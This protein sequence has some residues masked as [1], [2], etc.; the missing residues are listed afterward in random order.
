MNPA[1]SVATAATLALWPAMAEARIVMPASHGRFMMLHQ[2]DDDR[3]SMI[4]FNQCNASVS[5]SVKVF[6]E[7]TDRVKVNRFSGTANSAEQSFLVTVL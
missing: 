4:D 1:N 7:S 6:R 2:I 5:Q 3:D